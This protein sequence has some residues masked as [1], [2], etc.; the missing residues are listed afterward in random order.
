LWGWTKSIWKKRVKKEGRGTCLAG[1]DFGTLHVGIRAEGNEKALYSTGASGIWDL[2]KISRGRVKGK[3]PGNEG[4]GA[5]YSISPTRLL[6]Q[7][8]ELD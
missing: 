7:T 4:K 1:G 2:A 3:K 8:I 6:P 5:R